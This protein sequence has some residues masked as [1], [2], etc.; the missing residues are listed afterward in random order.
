M[1]ITYLD[2]EQPQGKITYLEEET[3]PLS[4]RQLFEERAR[5][6]P[7]VN[8]AKNVTDYFFPQALTQKEFAPGERNIYGD[9]FERPGAAIRSFLQGTGYKKG[10]IIPEEVPTFEQ[11]TKQKYPIRTTNAP[12][13]IADI[14]TRLPLQMGAQAVDIGT[15][16]AN[17]LLGAFGMKA[18]KPIAKEFGK[19][20]ELVKTT[21]D[22]IISSPLG[23]TAKR[24]FI[25]AVDNI[26]NIGN[27][28]PKKMDRNWL[29]SQSQNTFNV[30]D[31]TVKGIQE[32]YRYLYD[33][34]GIGKNAVEKSEVKNV[35][36]DLLKGAT[37]EEADDIINSLK[38]G[39][40]QELTPD[41]NTVKKIKD[42][43]QSDIPESVWAK[44]KKGFDLTPTQARKVK[45][46]FKLKG[47]TEKTLTGT[48]EGEYLSYLDKKATDVYRLSKVAKRMVIDQTGTPTETGRLVQAFSGKAGQAG[49]ENLFYRLKE[50]NE[51]AQEIITN[52][53]KF[54]KRQI[55]KKI[56]ATVTGGY[57]LYELGKR[58][59][60]QSRY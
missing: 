35:I 31:D 37:K 13:T 23:E 6:S 26:K 33:E 27:K 59:F 40:G 20:K 38:T 54:R 29:I 53:N 17:W 5:R 44:G 2:E 39:I 55:L 36:S 14:T 18:G 32:E 21:A 57:G 3:K 51:N 12:T 43:I 47:I 16:P 24:G 4:E 49:K 8:V 50:L 10:A 41:L 25:K 60:G 1:P 58:V 34:I 9:I 48:E 42:I 11:L 22:E 7:V 15:Q 30:A 45:A 52:M 19:A 56:G 28:F 46:Y